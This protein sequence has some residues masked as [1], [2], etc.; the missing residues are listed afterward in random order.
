MSLYRHIA[1]HRQKETFSFFISLSCA[2]IIPLFSDRQKSYYF[3]EQK[4]T[5]ELTNASHDKDGTNTGEHV[6]RPQIIIDMFVD[7]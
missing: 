2:S 7:P 3:S 5:K 6:N 1:R 4:K